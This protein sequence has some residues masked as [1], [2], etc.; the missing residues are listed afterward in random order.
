MEEEP[1]SIE[2]SQRAAGVGVDNGPRAALKRGDAM[3]GLE[4]SKTEAAAHTTGVRQMVETAV[5]LVGQAMAKMVG[6][7]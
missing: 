6:A 5:G 7:Q 1:Y 2:E 4:A 3:E